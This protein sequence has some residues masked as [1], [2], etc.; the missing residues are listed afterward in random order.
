M[1]KPEDLMPTD[2]QDDRQ[3]QELAQLDKEDAENEPKNCP[4]CNQEIKVKTEN[5]EF[6]DGMAGDYDVEIGHDRSC[7]NYK[8][9]I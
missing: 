6:N 3:L 5:Y 8:K 7:T 1:T 2:T 4:L 9:Q